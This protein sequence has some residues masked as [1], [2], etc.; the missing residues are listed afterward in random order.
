[1]GAHQCVQMGFKTMVT[2]ESRWRR[3]GNKGRQEKRRAWLILVP[4]L[5]N[6]WRVGRGRE[7]NS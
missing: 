7:E 4:Y 2:N 1:M 3:E 6:P 5:P